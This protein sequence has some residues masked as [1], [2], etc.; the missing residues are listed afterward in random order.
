MFRTQWELGNS[1]TYAILSKKFNDVGEIEKLLGNKIYARLFEEC[2]FNEN[3]SL[4]GSTYSNLPVLIPAHRRALGLES[5]AAWVDADPT[6]LLFIIDP[7]AIIFR[8]SLLELESFVCS[9]LVSPVMHRKIIWC[10]RNFNHYSLVRP[11]EPRACTVYTWSKDLA[12]QTQGK[13]WYRRKP[14]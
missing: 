13:L 14:R 4:I 6:K 2:V 5:C 1:L 3:T 9:L 10:N 7:W 8:I 12:Q 11:Y